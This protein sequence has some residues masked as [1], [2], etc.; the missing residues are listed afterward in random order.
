MTIAKKN[1]ML[2][3]LPEAVQRQMWEELSAQF[4]PVRTGS[5]VTKEQKVK[6]ATAVLQVLSG[7]PM[8]EQRTVLKFA[9]R[10]LAMAGD[11]WWREPVEKGRTA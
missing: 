1:P 9:L 11:R 7:L 6:M 8:P 4:D 2:T 5:A 3:D 10:I